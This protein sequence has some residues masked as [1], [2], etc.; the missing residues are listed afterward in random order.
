M[1]SVERVGHGFGENRRDGMRAHVGVDGLAEQIA[2]PDTRQ[3]RMGDLRRGVDARIGASGPLDLDRATGDGAERGLDDLLNG[4]TVRLA[5][6]ADE[7]GAVVFESELVARHQSR[8]P[9][10]MRVPKR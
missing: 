9:A 7:G 6:P 3:L 8:V 10:A 1:T 5:L 4:E 2:T